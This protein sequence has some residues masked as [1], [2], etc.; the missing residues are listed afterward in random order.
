MDWFTDIGKSN[1]LAISAI[2]ISDV[3]KS[4]DNPTSVNQND[5]PISVFRISDI[6]KWFTDI[7]KYDDLQ[8]LVNGLPKLVNR[9]TD[10]GNSI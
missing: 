4:T 1:R 6:G 2:R 9:F 8:I 7:G 10:I 3:C 5:F